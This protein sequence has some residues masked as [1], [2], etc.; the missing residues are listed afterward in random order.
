V[1]EIAPE[2]EPVEAV[3]DDPPQSDLARRI[4][5]LGRTEAKEAPKEV[6]KDD[7]D[8]D[9]EA[10]TQSALDILLRRTQKSAPAPAPVPEPVAE[11]APEP[12]P[13][14]EPVA[15]IA[16]EP[17]PEPEPVLE[18]APEPEPEP[19]PEPVIPPP[20]FAPVAAA[21]AVVPEPEPEPERQPASVAHSPLP[22]PVEVVSSMSLDAD[23]VKAA[24]D[25]LFEPDTP[26]EPGTRT[27]ASE[28]PTPAYHSS[29]PNGVDINRCGVTELCILSGVGEATA[30]AII[31]FRRQN[32]P[33]TRLQDLLQ[34]SG[35]GNHTYKGMTGLTAR[36][37]LQIAEARLTEVLGLTGDAAPSLFDV[38]DTVR[39]QMD[40]LGCFLSSVDGLVLA[41][42]STDANAAK[43][44]D[45][46]AAVA[47]Q[48][49][50][51]GSKALLQAQMP[52]TRMYT[53]YVGKRAVTFAGGEE[54]FMACVH[55]AAFPSAKQLRY[56]Q[57]LVDELFWY[58]SYR[59]VV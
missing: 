28:D 3:A 9:D 1:P 2:P 59:A 25:E 42:S 6:E 27:K 54:V 33:Y 5:A 15:Q 19:E 51:R 13:E 24:A 49:F 10:G 50:K 40:L 57:K 26:S 53:F 36:A 23:T 34:V 31:D 52:E 46:L 55:D 4:L 30:K 16:P 14:P 32:G 11:I 44:V 39:Q 29:A 8:I 47:P 18:I 21:A 41:K 20:A 48:L 22:E 17:E 43:L 56:L 12:E 45:S 58:C 7:G 37:S 35:L 38:A